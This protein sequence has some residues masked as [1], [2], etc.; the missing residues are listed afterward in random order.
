MRHPGVPVH[1]PN[2]YWC[3][4]CVRRQEQAGADRAD[5]EHGANPGPA[6]EFF[7]G[8]IG[9]TENA[10]ENPNAVYVRAIE[11]HTIDRSK[12]K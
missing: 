1:E 11:Q 6:I 9:R 10:Y 7:G 8:R 3:T 2:D 5:K 4:E 12:D